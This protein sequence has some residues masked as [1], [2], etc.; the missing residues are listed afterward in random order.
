MQSENG[1]P[2]WGSVR[3]VRTVGLVLGLAIMAG[4]S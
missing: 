1:M 4:L 3:M 2:P